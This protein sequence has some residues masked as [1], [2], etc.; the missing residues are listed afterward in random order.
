MRELK[1]VASLPSI[2]KSV[3]LVRY[4]TA[5]LSFCRL[6]PSSRHSLYLSLLYAESR[7]GMDIEN[8]DCGE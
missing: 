3:Y 4:N 6:M 2:M 5:A 7:Y 1:G 8:V